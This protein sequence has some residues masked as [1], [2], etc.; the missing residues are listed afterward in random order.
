MSLPSFLKS[1]SS[2]Q[3]SQA[4]TVFV[5]KKSPKT[6]AVVKQSAI[7]NMKVFTTNNKQYTVHK[8]I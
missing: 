1:V 5:Y 7:I 8:Y 4:Y 2:Y 6:F 3:L